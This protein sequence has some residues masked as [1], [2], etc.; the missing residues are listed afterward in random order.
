MAAPLDIYRQPAN[1]FV[2]DFIGTSTLLPGTLVSDR[3]VE[4]LGHRLRVERV[5]E[6]IAGG[7]KITL[8][9]RP[10]DVH[11]RPAGEPGENRLLGTVTFVRD[12]GASVE[13]TVRCAGVDILAVTTPRERPRTGIGEAVSLELPPASC[14]VLPS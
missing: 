12:L 7:G 11:I 9:V 1:A 3:M 2:A 6:S 14:V 10:E 4:V 5:P 8:S 13:F